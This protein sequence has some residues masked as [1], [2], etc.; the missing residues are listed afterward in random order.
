MGRLTLVP[1]LCAAV[2]ASCGGDDGGD[3]GSPLDA[4]L[5]YLPEDA[6][7]VIAIDT[8]V[9]GDQFKAL[10]SIAK[11]F[12]GGEELRDQLLQQLELG[13]ADFEED[14]KPILGNPFV[15]G[16]TN[17]QSVI[18]ESE[19]DDFVAAIQA[20]D[21]DA[22][23]DA[24]EREGAKRTG[25]KNG[26][27]LYEDND[28]DR[29]AI[30]DDV[31]VVAG[32]ERLLDQALEQRDSDDRL[33]EDT[34]EDGLADLPGDALVKVY[35][36]LAALIENDPDTAAARKVKWVDALDTFG[37]TSSFEEDQIAI[38]F[39]LATEDDLSDEDLP[40]AAGSEAPGIAQREGELGVG[41]RDLA[42]VYDFSLAAGQAA[43][44]SG[45]GEFETAK[46]QIDDRL[47]ISVDDDLL[48]QLNGDLS[49]SFNVSGGFG[50][51]AELDDP[52]AFRRALEKAAPVI[53]EFLAGTTGGA[54]PRVE[55]PSGGEGLYSLVQPGED[56]VFFGV[57][58]DVLVV[59]N[60]QNRAR[61][62]AD[63]Q[64]EFVPD[65]EGALVFNVDAEALADSLLSQL[66]GLEAL[67]GQ[68]LTR[69]L[70]NMTGSVEATTDGVRGTLALEIE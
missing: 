64:P 68:L 2:L 30:E 1:L 55:R 65:A 51:R 17:V 31:L 67:G 5:G 70:G 13:E 23:V 24:V 29:F 43:D 27:T 57:V 36:D 69:P 3:A 52:A 25:E 62:L 14:V 50:A 8:D 22:L 66:Q 26:A 58:N 49:F 9:D 21:K 44:P 15:V 54:T 45:F 46:R 34:F 11:K 18:D 42:Q 37:L 32:S 12:P 35:G 6:P 33:T 28:G 59:S 63:E 38:D 4:G 53:P 61:Q 20:G 39:N 48:G 60:D 16:G 40:L 47:G 41:L 19:D 7:L 10:E 56:T